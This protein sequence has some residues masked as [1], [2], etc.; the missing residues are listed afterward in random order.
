M[1]IG[2]A[3]V[4][5]SFGGGGTD[6]EAY[7]SRYEGACLSTTIDKY[8]YTVLHQRHDTL[9]H[10]SSYDYNLQQIYKNADEMTD[11]EALLIP[12]AVLSHLV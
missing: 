9:I 1:I 12:N 11:S 4:R 8:F 2:R 7:F 10:F 3:P 5:V 6:I